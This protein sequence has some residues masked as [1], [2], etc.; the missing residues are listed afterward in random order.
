MRCGRVLLPVAPAAQEGLEWPGAPPYANRGSAA[1]LKPPQLPWERHAGTVAPTPVPARRLSPLFDRVATRPLLM[2]FPQSEPPLTAHEA[3]SRAEHPAG[4]QVAWGRH[5]QELG[6]WLFEER[7]PGPAG[8][9]QTQHC[10]FGILFLFFKPKGGL[11]DRPRKY[12]S[13]FTG[14]TSNGTLFRE[15]LSCPCLRDAPTWTAEGKAAFQRR[16]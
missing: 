13:L 7:Q 9:T 14:F 10:Y 8:A 3:V 1:H 4:V 16:A 5:L 2:C 11:L 15:E 6:L 12:T